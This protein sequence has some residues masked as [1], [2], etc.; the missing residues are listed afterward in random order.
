MRFSHDHHHAGHFGHKHEFEPRGHGH[1]HSGHEW[2]E[3][4]GGG[5]GRRQ[6][7]F[8]SGELR[9]IL[10]KLI[11]DQPRHGYDL[12][13]AIED[14]T[15]GNYTPSA[16]VIYPALSILQD[17]NHIEAAES[18]GAR[19]AFAATRDGSAELAANADKVAALFA[20]LAA[21]AASREGTDSAPIRRALENLRAVLRH[22]LGNADIEKSTLHA[23]TA[24]LDEA[25][26]RIE[27][28]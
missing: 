13:R 4:H 22:R 5:R 17:L 15:A 11:A 14:L 23:V 6:R 16:G 26:Q 10:L 2:S 21:L 8:D 9:L 7:L 19:K 28:L 1:R 25:A 20:R 27:R 3:D 18:G 24:I 12:I